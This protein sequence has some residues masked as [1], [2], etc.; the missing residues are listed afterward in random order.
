MFGMSSLE[1][2]E[3]S[4]GTKGDSSSSLDQDPSHTGFQ[5]SQLGSTGT[6][7]FNSSVDFPDNT[8]V[9]LDKGQE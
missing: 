7:D 9:C 3:D 8:F 5:Y 2:H 6:L 4:P 1:F